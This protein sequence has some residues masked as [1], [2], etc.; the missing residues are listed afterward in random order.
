MD[1]AHAILYLAL[2][3]DGERSLRSLFRGFWC[4][5]ACS[6]WLR[7]WLRLG[8]LPSKFRPSHRHPRCSLFAPYRF[9]VTR[10]TRTCSKLLFE[11]TKKKRNQ[12]STK[13]SKVNT[14]S[15]KGI[16]MSPLVSLQIGAT[17]H[18]TTS[19]V[20][21]PASRELLAGKLWRATRC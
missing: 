10:G 17:E 5:A 18:Y 13:H 15:T 2:G 20:A 8:L 12:L 21:S 3:S 7:M 14:P 6:A 1:H 16:L 4:S 9:S 11:R 19:S